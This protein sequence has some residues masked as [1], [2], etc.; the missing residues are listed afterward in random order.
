M[1]LCLPIIP[2]SANTE[3]YFIFDDLYKMILFF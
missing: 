3:Y 2:I 1:H